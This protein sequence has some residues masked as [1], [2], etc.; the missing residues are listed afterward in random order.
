MPENTWADSI[1]AR[2]ATIFYFFAK[3]PSLENYTANQLAKVKISVLFGITAGN[4]NAQNQ[5]A[6]R[7]GALN[8]F[9]AI[10]LTQEFSFE[11]GQ[12][13]DSVIESLATFIGNEESTIGGF[14]HEIDKLIKFED[15]I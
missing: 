1:D 5:D 14:S 15:E 3:E 12:N 13:E 11:N 9:H 8:I 4:S 6:A 2:R 10:R 7:S